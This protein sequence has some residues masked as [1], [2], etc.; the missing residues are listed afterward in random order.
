MSRWLNYGT[1]NWSKTFSPLLNCHR[2]TLVW[3]G[4]YRSSQW[5]FSLE[6][7]FRSAENLIGLCCRLF[8]ECSESLT[9]TLFLFVFAFLKVDAGSMGIIFRNFSNRFLA[10]VLFASDLLYFFK[11]LNLTRLLIILGRISFS[12]LFFI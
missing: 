9:G 8:T 10:I 2:S 7:H 3:N 1:S 5:L 6:L 12:F 11:E 4:V